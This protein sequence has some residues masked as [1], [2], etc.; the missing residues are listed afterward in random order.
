M[1][2]EPKNLFTTPYID[3]EV[4]FQ[5]DKTQQDMY[6]CKI[7]HAYVIIYVH[8]SHRD[9]VEEDAKAKTLSFDMSA[10]MRAQSV[11]MMGNLKV[12]RWGNPNKNPNAGK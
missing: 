5:W 9:K 12:L 2:G 1:A 11:Q 6:V 4:T 7:D 8:Q 10:L 3:K